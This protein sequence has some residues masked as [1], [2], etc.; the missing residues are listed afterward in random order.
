MI[1]PANMTD[2]DLLEEL[3]E[4]AESG[5]RDTETSYHHHWS[6]NK[7]SGSRHGIDKDKTYDRYQKL[8][9]EA[10]NRKLI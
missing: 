6:S 1:N 10:E 5:Q 2:K 3:K 9:R 7:T 4:Y 8:L